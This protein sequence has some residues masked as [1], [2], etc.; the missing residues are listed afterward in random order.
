MKKVE[1]LNE[2]LGNI[3][4]YLLDQIMKGRYKSS[5]LIL[6][7]GCGR[8]R[9]LH[10]FIQSGF[11]LIGIDMN[12][13]AIADL[14]SEYTTSST[15]F[16]VGDL[17]NIKHDDNSFDHVICNAVLHFAPDHESFDKMFKELV[18]VLKPQGTFFIRMT[19]DIG[20]RQKGSGLGN[21]NYLLPDGSQRY[22]ITRKKIDE[23]MQAHQLVAIEPIKSLNV[24]EL[25][26]M[27]T[28][29]LCKV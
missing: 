6:D 4:I 9:N 16:E 23:L 19:S 24:D 17:A 29:V 27:T 8:G 11:T 14:Q 13:S 3:D 2:S 1:A 28:M 22:L 21:G 5:D 7:A 26:V 20:L 12:A 25:R 15:K 18:R 10:W